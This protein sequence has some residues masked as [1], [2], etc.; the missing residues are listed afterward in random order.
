MKRQQVLEKCK[1]K[2]KTVIHT[3]IHKIVQRVQHAYKKLKNRQQTDELASNRIE[4]LHKSDELDGAVKE[5]NEDVLVTIRNKSEK[6]AVVK[7][8]IDLVQAKQKRKEQ[9]KVKTTEQTVREVNSQ[10]VSNQQ[11]DER[12]QVNEK[13][14]VDEKRQID[15]KK[16]TSYKKQTTQSKQATQ[17]KQ[18]SQ[19]KQVVEKTFT[20]MLPTVI[21]VEKKIFEIEQVLLENKGKVIPLHRF[22]KSSQRGREGGKAHQREPTWKTM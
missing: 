10:E 11:V 18:I 20:R 5:V 17:K 19:R 14:E 15:G 6:Q 4:A 12:R 2:V 16:Q 8:P 7:E 22:S 3:T 1:S 13:R 9:S 21:K